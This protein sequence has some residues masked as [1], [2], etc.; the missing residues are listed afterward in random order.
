MCIRDSARSICDENLTLISSG[1][2]MTK[3]DIENRLKLSAD[4]IQLY[5]GFIFRGTD[6]LKESLEIQ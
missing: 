1:G 3:K 5:T 6:L 4:L 2:L